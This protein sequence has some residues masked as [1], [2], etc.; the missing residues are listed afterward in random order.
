MLLVSREADIEYA[1]FRQQ[2]VSR[3]PVLEAVPGDDELEDQMWANILRMTGALADV[4]AL[5]QPSTAS[6]TAVLFDT[7]RAT[8]LPGEG[9]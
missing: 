4:G 5:E 2:A 3:D 7:L 6:L 1:P 8:V 9:R